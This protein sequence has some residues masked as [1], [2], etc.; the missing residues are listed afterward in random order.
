MIDYFESLMFSILI[1]GNKILGPI[2]LLKVE[3]SAPPGSSRQE[4]SLLCCC[5]A[6]EL[7]GSLYIFYDPRELKVK[8]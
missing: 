4:E 5:G 6:E 2:F 3:K 1:R 7:F 8:G